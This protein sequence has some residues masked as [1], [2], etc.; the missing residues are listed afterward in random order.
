MNR[1]KSIFTIAWPCEVSEDCSRAST[2]KFCPKRGPRKSHEKTTK[3][4][5]PQRANSNPPQTSK[6]RAASNSGPARRQRQKGPSQPPL[7]QPGGPPEVK[8]PQGGDTQNS[9]ASQATQPTPDEL[10]TWKCIWNLAAKPLVTDRHLPREYVGLWQQVCLQVL[11]EQAAPDDMSPCVS[12]LFFVLPKLILCRPPGAESRK[13]R[14][15]RLKH[16]FQ[17]ASQGEWDTLMEAA[18]ARPDPRYEHNPG[19]ELAASKDGLSA[20]TAQRLYKAASQGQLG[21][22]W[23]Q[24]RSPPPLPIGPAEWHAAA[25]KLFPHESTE[26]PPLREECTPACWQPTEK[27]FQ[28]AICR[29]KKGRAADSGGWTTELAQG[30]LSHPQVRP[31]ALQWLHGLAICLNPFSGRQGLTHYHKLVCLDKGGGGVRPILIGMIWTKLVSHLLLAQARPDLEPF[32]KG[33]QFG[34]G[35]PQGGLAMTLSIRARLATNPTHV[36]ASLDFKNAFGTLKRSTC[37]ETLR[38]LCPQCPAWL[39]VVNVLL[40]RPVVINNPTADK[41]SKT[42]DGLPQGDPL[43]TLLFSTVMSEIVSQAVRAITSEVHV[44]SYVDD[45]I[46]TGPTEEVA[47]A[48]QQLPR[49][50]APSGLELQPAKTQVWAPHSECLRHTPFLR[51]LHANM[52]DPRGLIIVGEAMGNP[53]VDSFP[54][55]DEAFVADHLRGVAENIMA[56]LRMIACLPD[57]LQSG[58]AGVQVAW[59]LIAKTL[60]PRVVHLLRAHP[61]SETTELTEMLQE[62]L[63]D[64]VRQLMGV[65]STTADQLHVARLPVSAGGLGLPHL[66]SLAVIARC[67]ALATM[68]RASDTASYRQTLLDSE[69][70]MLF[71]RLRDVCDRDPATLAGNLVDPPPGLSLRHLSRK[72]THSRDSAAINA[73]WLRR[74]ELSEPLRHAWLR[75]LPGDNPARPEAH[76]GQGDWLHTLP[77]KWSNTL[78][79]PVFRWGLQQRLGF[80][81]PGAGE[82]C[83]RTP[84]GGKRCN[85]ILDPLGRHA[86]LCNK[87]LYT[88]RHDRVRDH[89]ALVARQAGLTAQVEQNMF[90]PGQTLEDGQPAPGSVRPIHRADLHI[91]E[92]TGSELWLDVRIHT[93]APDRPVARELLREE[94][95]KCRSYGQ[96]HGYDLNQLDQGMIPVVLEQYGRAAPGAH[97]IFQRLIQHRTQLLVRQGLASYSHAKRQASDELWHPLACLLLRAAWQSLAECMPVQATARPSMPSPARPDS[98]PARL[99]DSLTRSDSFPARLDLVSSRARPDADTQSSSE[100]ATPGVTA[101]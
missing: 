53:A 61:V 76:H 39:D 87:G 52:K 71:H 1:R 10:S 7:P 50:L 83:G 62:G 88:R 25:Q 5:P 65:P 33:R 91:I 58:Q 34:I 101:A 54:V 15:A 74:A 8:A 69:S 48:L 95:T 86:G 97:A 36:V 9:S 14:L 68:P 80:N 3:K 16:Q 73:L 18:L 77:G 89:I 98:H 40:A 60:P 19:L 59:A 96:R 78:L 23:R 22:A 24:L 38:K 63:Q 11:R 41:P 28:D 32:L 31:E 79:D 92:P 17:L 55:G 47:Q 13:D 99:D 82:P 46:L 6:R 70:G 84:P 57:K 45:T 30:A 12:D 29:L 2:R 43:S 67:S 4:A 81:A 75:N 64:A 51:D 72:L 90:V 66:P 94:Q 93:V 35:T 85:H 20:H 100:L 44:V 56:D 37:M 42:W 21:K 27:Q 26:G 49:L